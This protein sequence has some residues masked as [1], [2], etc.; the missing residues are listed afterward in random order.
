MV[1]I[2]VGYSFLYQDEAKC[3]VRTDMKR[4]ARGL[5]FLPIMYFDNGCSSWRDQKPFNLQG[6]RGV[7]FLQW[8]CIFLDILSLT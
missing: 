8:S 6:I 2:F 5:R 4:G 1:C 7:V 3:K